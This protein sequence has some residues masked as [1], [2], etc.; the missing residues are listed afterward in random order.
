MVSAS[1]C[2]TPITNHDHGEA[3]V[4]LFRPDRLTAITGVAGE[5]RPGA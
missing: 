5:P 3:Y 4:R 1:A 2:L